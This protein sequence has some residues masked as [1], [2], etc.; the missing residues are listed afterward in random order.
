MEQQQGPT[1][2]GSELASQI[3]VEPF[4]LRQQGGG[5]GAIAGAAGGISGD[6]A[7]ADRGHLLGRPAGIEPDVRIQGAVLVGVIGMA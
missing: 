1:G 4:E 6:Q 2:M 5:I 7:I 3:P